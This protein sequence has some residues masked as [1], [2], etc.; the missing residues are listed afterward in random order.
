[1]NQTKVRVV[2]HKG[3]DVAHNGKEVGD[4][5]VKGNGTLQHAQFHPVLEDGWIFTGDKGTVDE[6]GRIHVKEARKD[7]PDE[8][9]SIAYLEKLLLQH[10]KIEEVAIIPVPH[11][12]IGEIAHAF[13][14]LKNKQQVSK[15]E[16]L[17]FCKEKSKNSSCPQG[18]S[19]VEELPKTTSGKILKG[20]LQK[21]L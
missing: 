5:I 19:F 12:E 9:I 21:W 20:E 7:I 3:E 8:G 16:I 6:D 11:K 14:V 17:S 4:I 1:M 10:P 18:I 13:V 2:N 15:K